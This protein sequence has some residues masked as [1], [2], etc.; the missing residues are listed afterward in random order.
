MKFRIVQGL[1]LSTMFGYWVVRFVT[2]PHHL[3]LSML[4]MMGVAAALSEVSYRAGKAEAKQK[5]L[6]L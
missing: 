3:H 4:I 6:G 5:Q 1:T 2:H